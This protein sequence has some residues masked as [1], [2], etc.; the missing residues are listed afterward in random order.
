MQAHPA[1]NSL[2]DTP[3]HP[4]SPLDSA[5]DLCIARDSAVAPVAAAQLHFHT[6]YSLLAGYTMLAV[7]A[8]VVVQA[9]EPCSSFP[10]APGGTHS[11][12]L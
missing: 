2:S 8:V 6:H 12:A 10:S 11:S 4:V 3:A 7:D 9:V 5:S 1:Y